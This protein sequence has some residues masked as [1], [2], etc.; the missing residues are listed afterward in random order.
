MID[1]IGF[2]DWEDYVQYLKDELAKEA[3]TANESAL[4]KDVQEN[5]YHHG[6]A[7]GLFNAIKVLG[8]D[9]ASRMRTTKARD[10]HYFEIIYIDGEIFFDGRM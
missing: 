5:S 2:I 9:I 10:L 1:K 7:D 6:R 4:K 8:F 3:K